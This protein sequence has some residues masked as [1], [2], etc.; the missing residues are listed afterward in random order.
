MSE[1]MMDELKEQAVTNAEIRADISV[2]SGQID[3]L[4]NQ[5]KDYI[6]SSNRLMGKNSERI[7]ELKITVALHEKSIEDLSKKI[8]SL[9]NIDVEVATLKK[10]LDSFKE[11][12]N[13]VGKK[14]DK[15]IEGFRIDQ[16]KKAEEQNK[17]IM[18][19]MWKIIGA[20]L[21]GITMVGTLGA[22]I[23]NYILNLK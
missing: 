8:E 2:L 7:E 1:Q 20:F 14:L 13:N 11:D 10:D 15:F 12:I 22:M 21:A 5:L 23:Y 6:Q 19:L 18:K 16:N 9:E 17:F 3:G 4:K